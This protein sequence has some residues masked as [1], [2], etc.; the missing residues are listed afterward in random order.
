MFD[1]V[2]MSRKYAGQINKELNASALNISL[3]IEYSYVRPGPDLKERA[4][5]L[6]NRTLNYSQYDDCRAGEE[7]ADWENAITEC[8]TDN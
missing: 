3:Q 1:D 4:S 7:L 5:V 6:I 8:G 2:S